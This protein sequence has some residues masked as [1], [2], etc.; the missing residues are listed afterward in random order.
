MPSI[1]VSNVL[2]EDKRH[3][4]IALGRLS[5]PLRRIEKETAGRLG[6]DLAPLSAHVDIGGL[7]VVRRNP[8]PD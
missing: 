3:Q 8:A 1:D 5:W 4:V 2:S 6:G 7:Y